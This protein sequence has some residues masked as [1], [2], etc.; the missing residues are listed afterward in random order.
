MAVNHIF[1]I[2]TKEGTTDEQFDAL[3]KFLMDASKRIP[4]LLSLH[5]GRRLPDPLASTY[6]Q[7]YGFVATFINRKAR[8]DFL[9]SKLHEDLG[10]Y[11]IPL[12]A[13]GNGG[14]PPPP[15]MFAYEY[16]SETPT[17]IGTLEE[18]AH[19]IRVLKE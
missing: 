11:V 2:E 6:G 4:G 17:V 10:E 8:E 19:A 5:A 3:G 9:H 15:T 18:V 14:T 13:G 12:L 7:T 16:P 1:L